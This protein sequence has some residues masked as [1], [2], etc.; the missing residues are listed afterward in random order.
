MNKLRNTQKERN[1][2]TNK[3]C[4]D[5]FLAFRMIFPLFLMLPCQSIPSYPPARGSTPDQ[6]TNKGAHGVP[7]FNACVLNIGC[8]L[9]ILTRR[10]P[11]CRWILWVYGSTYMRFS[12][13]NIRHCEMKSISLNILG[14]NY[15]GKKHDM[16]TRQGELVVNSA[17]KICCTVNIHTLCSA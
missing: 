13:P 4:E 9:M 2:G 5:L 7:W 15:T 3:Y 10:A 8:E 16:Y 14:S 11:L 1:N 17:M 6:H 12:V